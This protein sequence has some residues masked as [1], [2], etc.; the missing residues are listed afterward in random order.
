V[1]LVLAVDWLTWPTLR[2]LNGELTG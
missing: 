2:E 1:L